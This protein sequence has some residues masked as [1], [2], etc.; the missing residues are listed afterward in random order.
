MFFYFSGDML[1]FRQ[2]QAMDEG[3][4]KGRFGTVTETGAE[5]PLSVMSVL[6][7]E[8]FIRS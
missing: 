1:Y 4:S 8:A 6:D 7:D 3:S 2:C 5:M